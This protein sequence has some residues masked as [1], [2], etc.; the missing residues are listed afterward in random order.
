MNGTPAAL[1]LSAACLACAGIQLRRIARDVAERRRR[2]NPPQPR[3][4]LVIGS[5]PT[6]KDARR[7]RKHQARALTKMG[8]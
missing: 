6:H 4:N 3:V 1:G 8:E 2:P 7:Q 5:P